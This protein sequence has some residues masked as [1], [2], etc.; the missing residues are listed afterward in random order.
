MKGRD[1]GGAH[2]TSPE[3]RAEVSVR[4]AILRD[5]GRCINGPLDERP[6]RRAGVVHGPVVRGGKCQHCI[7]VH[8]RTW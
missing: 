8:R 6:G 2:L 4:R 3:R 1:I 5:A 7:D